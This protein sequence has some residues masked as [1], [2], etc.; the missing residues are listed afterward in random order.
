LSFVGFYI[1][2][3]HQK[4]VLNL[5]SEQIDNLLMYLILGLLIGA[6]V[7]HFLLS[8][9]ALFISNPLTIFYIWQGGMSFYGALIGVVI[10]VTLFYR[11]NRHIHFYK[12][13]D[14]GALSAS[15][16]LIFGRLANYVNQELVGRITDVWW[17]VN[18]TTADGCRHPYQLYAAASHVLLFAL[19][20]ILATKKKKLHAG[21][22]FALFL[23]GYGLL[24]IATDFFR[25][26]PTWLGLSIWQYLSILVILIGIYL[27]KGFL[28]R[29]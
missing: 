21:Q 10:S 1:Y 15:V 26:D 18:F 7:F 19:L 4:K 5:T 17:C 6:R 8:D 24:R 13:L 23:V 28:K 9:F 27:Y 2:L 14:M 11:Q 20:V 16:A 22:L 12:L 3:Q 29:R 25:D